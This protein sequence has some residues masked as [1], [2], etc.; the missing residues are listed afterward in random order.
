M[1]LQVKTQRYARIE[2]D[3]GPTSLLD[4]HIVLP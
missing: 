3:I 2:S 4:A 1:F